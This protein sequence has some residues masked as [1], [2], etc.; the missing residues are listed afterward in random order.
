MSP[1]E[2][3]KLCAARL[4]GGWRV[5]WNAREADGIPLLEA[6]APD[7]TSG[8]IIVAPDVEQLVERVDRHTRSARVSFTLTTPEEK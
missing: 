8:V 2:A 5:R 6:I 3:F 1:W 7:A 4:P